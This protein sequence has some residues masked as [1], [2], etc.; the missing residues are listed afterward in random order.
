LTRDRGKTWLWIERLPFRDVDDI[1]YDAAMDRVLVSSRSGG[2][3]YMINPKDLTWKWAESGYRIALI[4][5][6]GGRLL[7]ASLFDGVLVEPPAIAATI[8]K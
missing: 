8:Q 2:Q 6:A 7:A 4:R 5:A 1:F 3:I